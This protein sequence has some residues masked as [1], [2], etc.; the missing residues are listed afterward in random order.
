[1]T[2]KTHK[3]YT[4]YSPILKILEDFQL[5]KLGLKNNIHFNALNLATTTLTLAKDEYL[6]REGEVGNHVYIILSGKV[7]ISKMS[8]EGNE[9]SF[10]ICTSNDICGE[11]TLFNP[12]PK[13]YFNARALTHATVAVIPREDFENEVLINREYSQEFMM[14]LYK[15]M[16]RTITRFSSLITYGKKGSLY[17]TLISMANSFGI[18]NEDESITIDHRMTNQELASFCSTTRETVNI[19]LNEL[20]KEG[21]ISTSKGRITINNMKHLQSYMGCANCVAAYCGIS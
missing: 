16:Q 15:H 19:F 11:L 21:T 7:L 14:W 20:K 13:Y 5:D 12:E 6:F 18:K 2:H 3:I 4:F 17:S 10:R 9:F 8:P 1:M